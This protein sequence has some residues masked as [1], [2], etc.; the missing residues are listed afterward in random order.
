MVEQYAPIGAKL[1]DMITNGITSFTSKS[2]LLRFIIEAP[3]VELVFEK[4]PMAFAKLKSTPIKLRVGISATAEPT[5]PI[6]K[7]V[8]TISATKK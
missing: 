4:S 2:F 5:P 7:I 8:E 1:V 3:I 6:E